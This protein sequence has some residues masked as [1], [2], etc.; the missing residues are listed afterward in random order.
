MDDLKYLRPTQFIDSDSPSVIKFAQSTIEGAQTDIEKAIKLYYAVRDPIR[1]SP[2]GIVLDPDAYKASWVLEKK[3]GFCIPKAIL[4][5]AAARVVNIPS[6]LGYADVRNHLASDRLIALMQTDEF[7]FHGYTELYLEGKW[8]KAT[9]AFN[10]GLCQ[11][12]GVKPLKFDGKVD[13][14]MHPYDVAGNKHMEY[15][16]D[17]GQFAD[18]PIAKM[19]ASFERAYPHL[20]GESGPGWPLKGNLV[21]EI[22]ETMTN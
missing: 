12:F 8:V 17:H 3:V 19:I 16:R 6:R 4:L 9:P 7:A 10:L 13:S 22:S 2:Y 11:R 14:I 5:A 21:Q 15:I 20:F 1:Y 18:F